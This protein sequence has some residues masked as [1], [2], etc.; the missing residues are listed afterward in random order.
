MKFSSFVCGLA[1]LSGTVFG[2][3]IPNPENEGDLSNLDKRQNTILPVTGAPGATRPRLEVRQLRAQQPNQWSLFLQ[4]MLR[5]E[6]AAQTGKTSYY[7]IA[8]IHGV[9]R[10]NWDGVGQCSAC[11]GADGYCTHDSILFL[12]WHRA[13][14]ALFEQEMVKVAKTIAATYPTATRATMQAAASN[15]RLP[16]WDWAARPPN[17]G[18]NM[19]SEVTTSTVSINGPS[20]QQTIRN[21]LFRHVF[22]ST[23]A[24]RYSPFTVYPG[25]FRYPTSNTNTATSQNNLA[26]NAFNNI[27][28]SLQDQV[29]NMFSTCD[30]FVEVGA[31]AQGQS[32]S[33][34]SNSLENIHNTVHTTAGGPRANGISGGHMTYLATA[35]FDPLFWLHH[36]NVDRLFAMWQTMYPSSYSGSQ[37][38][39][40]ATWTIA[41]GSTQNLNSPLTP[42]HQGTGGAFWTSIGVRDWRVFRYTYPE[43][44]NSAGTRTAIAS[45]INKLYGPGATATAGS[46]KRDALP[47]DPAEPE[48]TNSATA[49]T[50]AAA[51]G[52][53]TEP[54]TGSSSATP[55]AT[56]DATPLQA[57]NGSLYQYVANIATTRYG[58]GGSYQ[59]YLFNGN[60]T[61]D[62]PASWLLDANLIGPMGVLAQKGMASDIVITGTIP[63]TTTLTDEV[64]SGDLVSLEVDPVI[65][66]L[67]AN[68]KWRI[69][70]PTGAVVDPNSIPDF[71][72]SVYGST[73]TD[74]GEFALPVWSAFIPLA[75]IT[76]N[77]AGGATEETINNGTAVVRRM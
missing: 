27:R 9:P 15:L 2:W 46:S 67:K 30:E 56:A 26:I 63:L 36:C 44:A 6:N 45:Y 65:T 66:Y 62:D 34:C 12:G 75:E 33:R 71:E 70:G 40:H 68:L 14:L 60:P 25:T 64:T 42:F 19:P 48:E 37:V 4:A 43:F 55:S 17:G 52:A 57:N 8:G 59:I 11:T 20:G 28:G 13:Y 51:T 23:S 16:Y 76:E 35:A 38:A 54:A 18:N 58:L 61:I 72:V 24:L 32:S 74:P 10:Q 47:Q 1:A 73:A 22:Q 41:Q 53:T 69:A 7:Q 31:D 29:Y 21:P 39:P 49:A 3:A 50:T 5:M 77:K